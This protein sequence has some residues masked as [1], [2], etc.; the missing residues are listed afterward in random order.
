LP[1]AQIGIIGGS[2][3][4]ELDGLEKVTEVEVDTPF[5]TPSAPLMVGEFAGTPVA[6][7]PRHGRG[8]RLSPTEIPVKANIHALKSIGVTRVLSVSAMGS[9]KE[10][11]APLDYLV[12]DQLI[13]RTRLRENTFFGDGIVAHVSFADP[14]CVELSA[15]ASASLEG[16]GAL[17]TRG[18]TCVVMEGPAFSS[19]AES[20][21]YRSWGASAIG[22]TALPEAKLAREAELCYAIMAAMTDYDVWRQMEEDV[23]VETVVANLTKNVE[24]ARTAIK[25]F[26]AADVSNRHCTCGESLKGAIMTVPDAIPERR[27]TELSVIAGRYLNG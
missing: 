17:V 2:G 15:L 13:D 3:L 8:H 10:Q 5:G 7:L 11:L 9:L 24:T 19:R 27:K 6:F 18:G 25:S 26:L 20:N 14:F 12:P 1:E 21:L 16:A 23:T 4:Y 22:M